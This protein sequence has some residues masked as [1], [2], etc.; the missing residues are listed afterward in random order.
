MI[1]INSDMA[2]AISLTDGA[3]GDNNI[4]ISLSESE[5]DALSLTPDQ[6]RRFATELIEAVNK[7]EVRRTLCEPQPPVEE[8]YPGTAAGT[9]GHGRLGRPFLA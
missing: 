9:G 5:G 7:A 1:E 4:L 8:N 3:R 2:I 6:A